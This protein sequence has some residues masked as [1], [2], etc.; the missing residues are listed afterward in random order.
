MAQQATH[1][2]AFVTRLSP[3]PPSEIDT[4]PSDKQ[5]PGVDEEKEYES[6]EEALLGE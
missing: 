2:P 5:P 6:L 3:E 4:N 1:S